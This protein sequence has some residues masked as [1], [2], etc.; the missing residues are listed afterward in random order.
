MF[1]HVDI[2]QSIFVYMDTSVATAGPLSTI[3]TDII[4]VYILGTQ[5]NESTTESKVTKN[6]SDISYLKPAMPLN[7]PLHSRTLL[8]PF[9]VG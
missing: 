5:V 3:F 7:I 2:S 1:P 9:S 6:M 8:K 4:L